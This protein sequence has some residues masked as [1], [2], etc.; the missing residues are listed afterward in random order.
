MDDW[1]KFNETSLSE[2]DF[3]SPLNMEH[4]ADYANKK[5]FVTILI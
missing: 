3:Y 1:K 4:D 2:N 5:E